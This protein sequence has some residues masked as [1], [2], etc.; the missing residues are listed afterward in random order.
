GS[1]SSD[2][3][4]IMAFGSRNSREQVTDNREYDLDI[5]ENS[6]DVVVNELDLRNYRIERQ[7]TAY[8]GRIEYRGDGALKRL[9]L[10][11]LYS[12]FE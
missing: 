1:W 5:D 2:N 11:S 6:G 4:G 7:S 10:N 12:E 9:F 3:F 8:G